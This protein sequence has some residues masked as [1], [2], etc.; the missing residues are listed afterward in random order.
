M[1]GVGGW[2][3]G[4]GGG[5]TEETKRQRDREIERRREGERA[6][7]N[8]QPTTYRGE[9]IEELALDVDVDVVRAELVDLDNRRVAHGLEDASLRAEKRGREGE[10][11]RRGG[12]GGAVGE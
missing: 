9:R 2:C 5:K 3:G 12:G 6:R 8:E 10:R 4:G 1:A 11:E 7:A